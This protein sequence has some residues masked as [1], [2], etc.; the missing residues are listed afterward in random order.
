[1]AD[2]VTS[3]N[4]TDAYP[5]LASK[6]DLAAVITRVSRAVEDYCNRTF[7]QEALTERHDGDGLPRLWLDR[8]PIGAITSVTI[9]G[10]ALDNTNADAWGFN[11][12]TGELWRGQGRDDLRYA[13]GFPTGRQNVAVEYTGG[14]TAVPGPVVEATLLAIKALYD[15]RA[16]S[17]AYSSEKIGD[18][19]Y[20]LNTT[21]TGVVTPA[22]AELL[23]PYRLN[24]VVV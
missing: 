15:R 24:P 12:D 6:A 10:E 21:T 14:Y 5:E 17:G 23:N 20:T 22:V 7:A 4:V 13:M 11:P 1:M 9:N 19:Q 8:P 3:Q 18:Y 16:A 2:L